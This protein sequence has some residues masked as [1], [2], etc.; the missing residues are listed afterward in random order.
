MAQRETPEINAGSMADIAFLLLI[1]FLV[2]TT[3]NSD[4]GILKRLPEKI[5]HP[6][7]IAIHERNVLRINLNSNNE[8]F[9]ED[10]TVSIENTRQLIIGFIDNGAGTDKNNNPCTWCNGAK[11]AQL[12]DHP[13]K[14]I[15][16]LQSNR[17]T[18]YATYVAM[19]NEI[20]GAYNTLRGQLAQQLYGKSYTDLQNDYKKDKKNT[21]LHSKIK[22]IKEKYPQLII[23]EEPLK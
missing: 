19:Q 9:I 8:I 13:S 1:F 7:T 11:D 3:M 5:T 14:A 10:K 17:S 20:V 6:T 4:V 12:S 21:K 23:E 15:I 18:S 2:T 16:S 22:Q